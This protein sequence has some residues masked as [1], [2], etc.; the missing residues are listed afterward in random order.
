M[1]NKKLLL[2]LP[3]TIQLAYS[4]MIFAE[5][6]VEQVYEYVEEPAQAPEPVY[7]D[8]TGVQVKFHED[9]SMRAIISS[10]ESELM[11]GDRKD[12]RQAIKKATMRAKAEIAKF[13]KESITSNDVMDELT[14]IA[15]KANSKGDTESTRE[16]IE[17]QR[18]NIQNSASA[19]LSGIVTLSQDINKDEKYVTVVLGVKEQTIN[20]ASKISNK[21]GAGIKQ[22][23]E[24]KSNS[25]TSSL[26]SGNSGNRSDSGGRE[27]RKS[28]M[29]DNF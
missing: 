2:V 1:K 17:A 27:I 16:V 8:P 10:A 12:I 4:T 18:E 5:E 29:Y 25:P 20:A 23:Q 9:G 22:G 3:L 24:Y 6:S 7:Q 14:N 13:M 11:F 15:S 19:I 28:K 21:I 26:G